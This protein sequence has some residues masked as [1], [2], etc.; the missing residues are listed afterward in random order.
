MGQRKEDVQKAWDSLTADEKASFE[1][2]NEFAKIFNESGSAPSETTPAASSGYDWGKF[3]PG[4]PTVARAA[5]PLIGGTVGTL[6]LPGPGTA[7]GGATGGM[8]GEALAQALE[9]RP[10]TDYPS[11]GVATLLGGM[12]LPRG[13]GMTARTLRQT[14]GR[15]MARQAIGQ[16]I[17]GGMAGAA[18][19]GF[20]GRT[21]TAEDILVPAASGAVTG[22][23][24]TGVAAGGQRVLTPLLQRY[25][26]SN[27]AGIFP[28]TEKYLDDLLGAS[29]YGGPKQKSEARIAAE[30]QLAPKFDVNLSTLETMASYITPIRDRINAVESQLQNEASK[31]DV[32]LSKQQRQDLANTFSIIAS[33]RGKLPSEESRNIAREAGRLQQKLSGTVTGQDALEMKRFIDR[34]NPKVGISPTPGQQDYSTLLS[35]NGNMLRSQLHTDSNVSTLLKEQEQLYRLRDSLITGLA[36]S[37]D[38]PAKQKLLNELASGA[39]V[40]QGVASGN[41]IQT[42]A[43]AVALA[44]GG[45]KLP[46]TSARLGRRLQVMT[47]LEPTPLPTLSP[48]PVPPTFP[49]LP[50]ATTIFGGPV[51]PSSGGGFTPEELAQWDLLAKTTTPQRTGRLLPPGRTPVT[52]GVPTPIQEGQL[53]VPRAVVTER[54]PVRPE[55]RLATA[56]G[57]TEQNVYG[58]EGGRNVAGRLVQPTPQTMPT[59]PGTMAM[60]DAQINTVLA[61]TRKALKSEKLSPEEKTMLAEIEKFYSA[62]ER[63]K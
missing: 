47:G 17:L 35:N 60:T 31:F 57:L 41:P 21:P 54:I 52:M 9:G 16:G 36:Q 32:P 7:I 42:T 5:G 55:D 43:G 40:V 25:A 38:G 20:E 15:V 22:A 37:K 1:N 6:A 14:P 50:P 3:I 2:F 48:R 44:T 61:N 46:L 33:Q 18:Q 63:K 39:N 59:G 29:E 53:A 11:L 12:P 62:F 58:S 4:L 10:E 30:L 28:N 49:S 56:L 34:Q 19:A 13:F 45:R 8:L 51:P 26:A 24:L 23:T 27:Y